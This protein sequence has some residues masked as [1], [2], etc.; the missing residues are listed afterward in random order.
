MPQVLN[1]PTMDTM[2]DDEFFA[3][4]EANRLNGMHFER[5]KYGHIIF[6]SPP[7]TIGGARDLD[8]AIEVG[9]WAKQNKTGV[10]FGP[11]TGFTLPD[12]SIKSPDVAWIRRDRW[13]Q[14]PRELRKKFAPIC[15]DFVVEV[16]SESDTWNE[17]KDKMREYLVNGCQL[18][19]LI[20]PN[21]QAYMIFTPQNT[22]PDKQPFGIINGG[23][24]LEGL[25][26]DL[27]TIF[28]DIG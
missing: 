19:W 24:V 13:E 14:I 4:C 26:I 16:M 15:P 3:L 1:I 5:D 22:N 18:G 12:S 2:N 25:T 23:D 8:I 11:A 21:E 28:E 10:A 9:Y 20:N 27:R 7:G 17:Q 6:M